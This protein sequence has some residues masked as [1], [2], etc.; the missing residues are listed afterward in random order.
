MS[1]KKDTAS[2]NLPISFAIRFITFPF[3]PSNTADL[4]RLNVL[5][6]NKSYDDDIMIPLGNKLIPFDTPNLNN[7]FVFWLPFPKCTT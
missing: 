6:K 2:S 4:E 5:E 1:C 3:K 7:Q